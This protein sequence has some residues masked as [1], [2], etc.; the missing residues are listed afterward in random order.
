MA[1]HRHKI[2]A[3]GSIIVSGQADGT[4]VR[5]HFSGKAELVCNVKKCKG[6]LQNASKTAFQ[7]FLSVTLRSRT[8]LCSPA[9]FADPVR[10]NCTCLAAGGIRPYNINPPS[11]FVSAR[12]HHCFLPK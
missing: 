1:A 10:A 7:T 5:F 3:C 12:T 11:G 9:D 4:A 8:D 6:V 2:P